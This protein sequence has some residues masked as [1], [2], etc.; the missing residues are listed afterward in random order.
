[1][2]IDVIRKMIGDEPVYHEQTGITLNNDDYYTFPHYP[3]YADPVM[4]VDGTAITPTYYLESGT[5]QFSSAQTGTLKIKYQSVWFTDETIQQMLSYKFV[6]E[7]L[8]QIDTDKFVFAIPKY[9]V[10]YTITD[11]GSSVNATFDEATMTFTM[12]ATSPEIKGTI[13]D[14]YDTVGTL[15]L[16]KANNPQKIRREFIS[17]SN[18]GDYPAVAQGLR[19]QADYWFT[20][21]GK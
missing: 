19:E 16:M 8:K 18:W 17:F 15:L 3:L 9:P 20:F 5:A 7:M 10:Y 13:V 6:D 11:N 21:S 2:V 4:E 14:I 12:T 1:M